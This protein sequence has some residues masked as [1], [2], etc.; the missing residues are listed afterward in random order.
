MAPEDAASIFAAT[1][2]QRPR[3]Q[4]E[5]Q[6]RHA[7]SSG[8]LK[9]GQKLPSE[10]I[11]A[12]NFGVSRT[13]VRE[14]LRSLVTRGLI[15]KSPGASG[16]SFVRSLDHETLGA[17]LVHD[18]ENL[19]SAGSI[20]FLEASQVRRMLELP[21]A[22]LAARHRSPQELGALQEVIA[23]QRSL[24]HD[25]PRVPELDARFH[26]LISTASGN[27]VVAAFV[28]ALHK[29]TE[30]VHHLH[31]D[32]EVGKGTFRQHKA[33]VRAIER[34]DPM[35]AEAAMAEHLAYL[36]RHPRGAAAE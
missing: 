34:Q 17:D 19:L 29:V 1:V 20:D 3:Q 2:V 23:E 4:V 18:I 11:L 31:L 21:S 16:G 12:L 13:T 32:A 14:A 15:E 25:D 28:S 6:I 30:P 35:A 24:S 36:E 8:V 22:R 27:R 5:D 7:V 33:I 9:T 26:A 10:A